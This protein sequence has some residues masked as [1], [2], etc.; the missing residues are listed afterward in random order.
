[1]I[2]PVGSEPR[3]GN[4]WLAV[5][6]LMGLAIVLSL[7]ST[8]DAFIAALSDLYGVTSSKGA[9]GGIILEAPRT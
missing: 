9:D 4:D 6:S 5:P 7:C 1:M 8:S 2:T 3:K